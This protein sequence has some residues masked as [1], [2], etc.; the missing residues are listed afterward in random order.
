M[1]E[2][3]KRASTITRNV[4]SQVSSSAMEKAIRV[5]STPAQA[6]I[7]ASRS[8]LSAQVRGGGGIHRGSAAGLKNGNSVHLNANG[9]GYL[10]PNVQTARMSRSKIHPISQMPS[11]PTHI[12]RK[13]VDSDFRLSSSKTSS[14][15]RIRKIL[16]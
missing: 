7:S 2:F 14:V 10:N 6:T 5:S 11:N 1:L 3:G 9:A 4:G 16:G 15:S 13:T 12:N 8:S